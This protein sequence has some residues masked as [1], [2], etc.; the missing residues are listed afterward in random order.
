MD[1]NNNFEEIYE[2]KFISTDQLSTTNRDLILFRTN[3]FMKRLKFKDNKKDNNASSVDLKS[4]V[5][6]KLIA[7]ISSILN[8]PR[9]S[10]SAKA[11]L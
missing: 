10:F 4:P 3:E 5:N 1:Y 7:D 6:P 9:K 11:F 8:F 2:S